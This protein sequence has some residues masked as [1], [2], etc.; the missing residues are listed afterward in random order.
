MKHFDL[1]IIG[2]G[3]GGYV[4]AIR[5]AQLGLK[6][7]VVEA[8]HLGG[9]C[10]NWGCIPT[11]ALLKSAEVKSI[12]ENA[13]KY[14]FKDSKADFNFSDIIARSRSVSQ[15]LSLGIGSLLKKNK[16]EVIDGFAKFLNNK[17]ISVTK[18]ETQF[19]V[20]ANYFIVA[21]GA[22][23]RVISGFEP[24]NK[25]IWTYREAMTASNMPKSIVVVG[26]GAIGVEFAYFYRALGVEVTLVEMAPQILPVEDVEIANIARKSF[27]KQ[28]IKILTN[29]TVKKVKKNEE[30]VTVTVEIAGSATEINAC[31]LIMAVGV[32]PN[33]EN[34][35][36]EKTKIK[37]ENGKILVNQYL[38]TAEENIFAIG[39]VVSGPWL[40]H[41]ASHEG[42][43]ASEFIASKMQKFDLKK[44]HPIKPENIPACTYANP[45]IASIGLT[46]AK[47]IAM[48][49]KIKVGRFPYLANGKAI[50]SGETEGLIKI[51]FEEKTGELLGA[52]LIGAE[53]VEMIQSIAIAKQAEL[54]EEDLIHSIF[55]HPT[56]SEMIHEA[57]LDAF[58][59][60]IHF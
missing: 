24:D 27:E 53:V 54:T 39:D 38:N 19:E 34:I 3:P 26:S 49:K 40:A 36:L 12:I 1:C 15:K 59:R 56:M 18:N 48:G 30:S 57:T 16:V 41:K 22:R 35:S 42:I 43:I 25:L 50:A 58:G 28:G 52:H 55:P 13:S 7:A 47:A 45:Q 37:L 31:R 14:G 60:A 17:K 29:A 33:V 32:V 51:I 10:L 44:I 2:A 23:A 5:G 9:I 46:E 11:K 20:T 21:T 8:N 4:A 6:V